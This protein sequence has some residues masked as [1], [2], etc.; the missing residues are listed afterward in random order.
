MS[1]TMYQATPLSEEQM[2]QRAP[3]IFATAP[4]ACVSPRYGFAPT[5]EVVRRLFDEGW[6]PVQARETPVRN[7][8][9]FGYATHT[10]RFR[11]AYQENSLSIDD[12]LP[13]LVLTNSH[14]GSTTYQLDI[15]LLRL[16]CGN[17][18]VVE[19]GHLGG[20]I[21]VRHGCNIIPAVIEGSY[22]LIDEVPGIATQVGRFQQ[23]KLTGEEQHAF[24]EAA[25]TARYGEDWQSLSPVRP[26][27]LL[28]ARR[29]EDASPDLWSTFN[30][31]QE[32][33]VRGGL[34]GRSV[35]SGRKLRTRG[36]R[37]IR[38]DL[39]LNRALWVLTERITELKDA[40]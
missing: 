9:R 28:E 21:H 12:C 25:L 2:M 11:R 1:M 5:I 4:H 30:V 8:E 17:G 13:E 23:A 27:Q 15:G 35:R 38:E 37:G 36:I 34:Q 22:R 24:A 33:L 19:L 32:N 31:V 16:V 10:L 3:S 20:G 26:E 29:E 6:I 7:Q 14:D 39:R 18:L 40:A